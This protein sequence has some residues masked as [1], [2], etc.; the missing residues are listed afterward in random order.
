MWVF[1]LAAC[2]PVGARKHLCEG[3]FLVHLLT[4]TCIH[5]MMSSWGVEMQLNMCN[6]QLLLSMKYALSTTGRAIII[7]VE[8]NAFLMSPNSTKI[9]II[10]DVHAGESAS[11]RLHADRCECTPHADKCSLA[12]PVCSP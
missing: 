9:S 6:N 7:V 11:A 10:E 3:G 12:V 2:S 8:S 4:S 1:S 5:P